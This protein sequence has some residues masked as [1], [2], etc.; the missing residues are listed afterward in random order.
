VT[1][2][3]QVSPRPQTV[4]HLALL[5][6]GLGHLAIGRRGAAIALVLAEVVAALLVAYLFIGL[7]DG[8]WY[9]V[10]FLAGFAF[11]M[12]WAIQAMLAYQRALSLLEAG[13]ATLPHPR[14]AAIGLAWLT[15][16]LL[17][18]GTGFWLVSGSAATPAAVLDRFE[19]SWPDL[20][21]GSG[22]DPAL[23]LDASVSA[24]AR[25]ALEMLQ[26]LCAEGALTTDCASDAGDLLRD[27]RIAV[28]QK[29][30]GAASATVT[31]VS[32]ERRPSRFLGLF[33]ATELVPVPRQ[34]I[35]TISL[36]AVPALLP[37]GVD[38][39]AQR[40][41]IVDVTTS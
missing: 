1:R 27:V 11:L 26:R 8:T 9:V 20:A 29:G 13:A 34:T 39:G 19:T 41:R 10:P 38:L 2:A 7:A 25:E 16:P 36:R 15:L 30:P 33:A 28:I 3:T 23:G 18:G 6:W 32:F 4:L 12:A 35:L 40:W 37:G 5:V 17:L 22:L 14:A 31:V 24:S 21:H